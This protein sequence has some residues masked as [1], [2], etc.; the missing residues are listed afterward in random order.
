MI[1]RILGSAAG[2]GVPQWN[3]NCSNCA[4]ARAGLQPRRTQSGAAVSADGVRWL[5]LNCSPDIAAQIESA[6]SLQPKDI[7]GTP[8]TGMLLTDANVDHIGGLATLRQ[9]GTHRFVVR[10]SAV[11]RE[12]ASAQP[13]FAPFAAPPHRWLD[14]PFDAACEAVDDADPV[15]TALQ[16]RAIPVPGTTPGFDGRRNIYGAVVAYEISELASERRLLFAPVFAAIDEP[17]RNAIARATVAVLDGS[18]YGDEEMIDAGLMRKRA[19]DLGHMPVGGAGGSLAQL[20][21]LR[22]RA[23]FTHV[24][25]S[26]PML[27]KNSAAANNVCAAGFELAYDGM[28]FEL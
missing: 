24:N 8:I 20:R 9:S 11:V 25:N 14:V 27:E 17:L 19:R 18:F 16:V 1:V 21:D 4:A 5:L 12:I 13:A 26:N 2:G 6:S 3:C 22:T 23:I 15:G 10:S 28:E 7:R